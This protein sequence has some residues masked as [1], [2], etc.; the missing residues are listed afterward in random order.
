MSLLEA[1]ILDQ[2]FE[3]EL[4][5]EHIYGSTTKKLALL[6]PDSSACGSILIY[7]TSGVG[8]WSSFCSWKVYHLISLKS[9]WTHN[10][11]F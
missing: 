9:G 5:S 3:I 10:S 11:C 7:A 2:G 4:L 6:P 1:L 8:T